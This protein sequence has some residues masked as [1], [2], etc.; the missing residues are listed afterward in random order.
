MLFRALVVLIVALAMPV[1]GFADTLMRVGLAG[2]AGSE[3]LRQFTLGQAVLQRP[4]NPAI[5]RAMQ[6]SLRQNGFYHTGPGLALLSRSGQ[7]DPV[8]AWDGNINGGF[9]TDRFDI[10]GLSFEVD[11]ARRALPGMV[12]GARVSGQMRLAYGEGHFLDM[13]GSV[14]AAY[15]PQHRI[16]RAQA[17]FEVCARNH[18]TG[19]TFADACV[20]AAHSHR[21]LVSSTTGTLTLGLARLHAA[22]ASE[23]EL[24]F[25][26]ARAFQGGTEQD[27]L[28]LGWD[29]VWNRAVTG[30]NLTLAAPVAGETVMRQRLNGSVGWLWQGRA[31]RV[32]AW[33]QRSDGGMLLGVARADRV[34][35]I[36]LSVQVRP[37]VTVELVHQVTRSSIA[38]FDE[39]R[40]GV[41]LLVNLG[42][43]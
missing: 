11:P 24:S 19:W 13:R 42:R 27:S 1:T 32:G 15:S 4:D 14:E 2:M 18:L 16:G 37:S 22:R 43:R 20:T 38:L 41:N 39:N 29:A 10:F 7:I 36:T 28:S 35:G 3:R 25:D 12:A 5:T 21:S 23:H 33:H 26:V 17:G 8:L 9:L 34:S 40:T 6:A 30:L 31:M